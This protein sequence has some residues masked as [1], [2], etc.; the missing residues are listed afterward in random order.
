MRVRVL[1]SVLMISEMNGNYNVRCNHRFKP[2]NYACKMCAYFIFC[3]YH[4][5]N[6]KLYCFAKRSL[7]NSYIIQHDF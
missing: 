5:L 4:S 7:D 6:I 2:T 1:T 3:K